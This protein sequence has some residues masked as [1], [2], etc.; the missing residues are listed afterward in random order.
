MLHLLRDP[1]VGDPQEV[2]I[3]INELLADI[4]MPSPMPFPM[5]PHERAP[6]ALEL[7]L[8]PE[9]CIWARRCTRL[10]RGPSGRRGH[11]VGTIGDQVK[12]TRLTVAGTV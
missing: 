1:P 6:P 8:L 11:A 9:E 12:A 2:A 3:A 4:A 10:T 7:W 5:P